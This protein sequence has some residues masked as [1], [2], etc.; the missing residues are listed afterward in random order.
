MEINHFSHYHRLVLLDQETD[1]AQSPKY[2]CFGCEE[3]VEGPT[4]SCGKCRFFLHKKCAELPGE[5]NHPLHHQ[6]PLVLSTSPY[7]HAIRVICNLCR[8]KTRKTKGFVYHGSSCKFDLD[9]RCATHPQL[10]AGDFQKLQHFSHDH[11]LIFVQHIDFGKINSICSGCKRPMSSPFYCCPNCRFY[12]HKKCAELSPEITHHTHQKHPLL[13]LAKAPLHDD[14]YYDGFV[15]YC[16][17]CEFGIPIRYTFVHEHQ[18]EVVEETSTDESAKA[19]CSRCKEPVLDSSSS[20]CSKCRFFI[21][22]KCVELPLEVSHPFHLQHPLILYNDIWRKCNVCLEGNEFSYQCTSCKFN[23]DI[24]CAMHPQFVAGDL[25]KLQHFS[26][27]HPLIF[28]EDIHEIE[29]KEDVCSGCQEPMSTPFYCCPDCKFYLHKKCAETEFPLEINHPSHRKH[30]LFCLAKSPPH[31]EKCSCYLCKK[32]Y[33]GFVYYCSL[34]EFGFK[35][36]D[37]FLQTVTTKIH[38][39]PLIPFPTT[40]PFICNAC[41]TDGYRFSFPYACC[42]CGLMLHKDCVSLSRS[43]KITRHQHRLSHIYF[44]KEKKAKERECNI[45]YEE[46]NV[47]FGSYYCSKCNYFAHVNCAIDKDLLEEEEESQLSVSD[48]STGDISCAFTV[49]E[50]GEIKHF[51]HEHNLIF[52]DRGIKDGQSCEGCMRPIATSFY[53]CEDCDF[54]IHEGCARL[55]K[56]VRHW[57]SKYSMELLFYVIFRCT[58]CWLWNSG[59]GYKCD[60][61]NRTMCIRC[62]EILDSCTVDRHEHPLFFDHKYKGNCHGCGYDFNFT[63]SFRC[64]DKKCKFAIDYKCLVLPNTARYKY[65]DNHPLTLTFHDD[66]HQSQC[67]CDICEED[68]DPNRWFYHCADC[69]VSAHPDCVLRQS[70]YVKLGKPFRFA[71]YRQHPVTFVKID[72]NPPKCNECDKPCRDELAIQCTVSDCNYVAHRDCLFFRELLHSDL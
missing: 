48:D 40:N 65:D 9:L 38:E 4:Y 32:S 59:F 28:V 56:K 25:Q 46:V 30:P 61:Y 70:P 5:I 18:L 41:G 35:A 45:C 54:F 71:N 39:H 66:H 64:K 37:A 27:D 55:L 67:Y 72:F 20:S 17:I 34:C 33:K 68:R 3:A 43:I 1:T 22:E 62:H 44:F 47:E 60:K 8:R 14:M 63:G 10:V 53:Y 24:R 50:P 7:G 12:L 52:S 21:H 29:R 51:A 19:S 23:L 2:Y 13:L 16:S 15:Y 36:A 69:D 6:H 31:Q 58:Y 42:E 11:P 49:I 26:H 57:T